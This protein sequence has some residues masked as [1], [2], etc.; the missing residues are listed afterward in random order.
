MKISVFQGPIAPGSVEEMLG[1]MHRASEGAALEGARLLILPELFLT[2]YHIG[3]DRV[4]GL[5][6]PA[7]GPAAQ[8]AAAIARRFGVAILYGYPEIA[9]ARV[10]NSA[11]LIERDGRTLANFRKLHLFGAIDGASFVPGDDP[12][13]IAEIDGIKVGILICYD[14]EFPELVRGL[15]LRG[16]DLIA[17]PTAQMQPYEFVPRTLIPARAYENSVFMAYANR[18]GREAELVYTGESCILGPDGADLA[19]AGTGEEMI[20]AT[21]DPALL[22][23]ARVLNTYLADRRPGLYGALTERPA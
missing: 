19:R 2:G 3:A 7:D 21:L 13:V 16:V 20:F 1:V 5:A 8:A 4:R 12:V 11:L 17:V 22:A 10:H 15:A 18:C 9:A 23:R 14:V 6:Q